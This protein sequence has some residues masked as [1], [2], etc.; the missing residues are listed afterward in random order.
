MLVRKIWEEHETGR[1]AE[2][3]L[4]DRPETET[5]ALGYVSVDG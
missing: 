1:P 2:K 4:F 5:V 3:L